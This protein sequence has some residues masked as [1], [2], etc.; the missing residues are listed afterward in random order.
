M[1]HCHHQTTHQVL[2]SLVTMT[3][4]GTQDRN[5]LLQAQLVNGEPGSAVTSLNTNSTI[6]CFAVF[7]YFLI[8]TVHLAMEYLAS[9]FKLV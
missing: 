8:A 1:I 7:I 4:S 9:H 2:T 6:I 5:F 3:H